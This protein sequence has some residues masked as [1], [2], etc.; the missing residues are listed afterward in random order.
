V[1]GCPICGSRD[2]ATAFSYTERP[3][4]ET[5]F[6]LPP[7]SYRREYRRCACCRH[8]V[9]VHELDLSALYAGE[10][11]DATYTGNGI[12]ASY[13]RIMSLSAERSDNVQ[14][15]ARIREVLG[16]GGGRR[17]LDVGSGL[18]V[19]SARMKEVG[20]ACTALDPDPRAVEHA[21]KRVGVEA[22]CADFMTAEGLGEFELITLNKVLEHVPDPVTMLA[23]TCELLALEGAVYVELPDGEAAANDPDGPA[24]EEFFIEHLHVFSM[25]SMSLLADRAGLLTVHAE[26]LREPSGKY[27]LF[28]FLRAG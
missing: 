6:G 18:A 8:L 2:L 4:G 27:T 24:R 21:R 7:E 19:F 3:P 15:V 28:A 25:S 16:E 14:R 26:R 23:R 13:E 17:V 5:D 11:V 1:S 12:A 22:V 9:S 10:Y 20:W